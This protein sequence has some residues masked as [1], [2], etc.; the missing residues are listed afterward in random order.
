MC[1]VPGADTTM[2]TIEATITS[3]DR[4]ATVTMVTVITATE[5]PR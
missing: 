5:S 2:R 1:T 3:T 4:V